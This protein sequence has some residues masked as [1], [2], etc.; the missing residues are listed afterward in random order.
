[1]YFFL[2]IIIS[3][4][5]H[6]KFNFKKFKAPPVFAQRQE[7]IAI[8]GAGMSGIIAAKQLRYLGFKVTV[9][10]PM[11][12]FGGRVCTYSHGFLP[13]NFFS[14]FHYSKT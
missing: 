6:K 10:E 12:R 4:K 3:L 5:P 13:K 7:S 11:Q 9:I 1:M 8:L 2:R 14:F